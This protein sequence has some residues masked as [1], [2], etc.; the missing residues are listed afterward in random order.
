MA[1][2]VVELEIKPLLQ[3]L[4]SQKMDTKKEKRNQPVLELTSVVLRAPRE[5]E[6]RVEEKK[7]GDAR[8]GTQVGRVPTMPART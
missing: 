7:G 8:T 4:Q 3:S 6:R 2:G 5:V 1:R